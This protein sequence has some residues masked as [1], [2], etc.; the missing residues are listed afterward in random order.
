MPS[1]ISTAIPTWA[2]IRSSR[3]STKS[4]VFARKTTST[5]SP[6]TIFSRYP[7]VAASLARVFQIHDLVGSATPVT[8]STNSIGDGDSFERGQLSGGRPDDRWVLAGRRA[9]PRGVRSCLSRQGAPACRSAGRPQGHAARLARAADSR[10]AYSTRTSCR[11]TLIG[12]TRP[13]VCI[14]YACPISAG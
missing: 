11:C 9:R 13:R 2:K 7:K 8:A 10:P 12:S 5:R 3:S 1:G 4:S 6:P 14:F